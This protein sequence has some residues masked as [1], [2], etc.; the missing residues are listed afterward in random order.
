MSE[1]TEFRS[2]KGIVSCNAK[3]VYLFVTNIE[4]FRQFIP[5]DTVSEWISDDDSCRFQVNGI[6]TVNIMLSEKVPYSKVVYKGEALQKNNFS[7]HLDISGKDEESSVAG[8]V[9]K[10]EMDP[11]MKMI[12]TK[13]A[14]RFLE[15]LVSEME[16]FRNW[17]QTNEKA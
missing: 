8:L 7:I 16:K 1:I 2:R 11:F 9:L 5:S 12:I 6:G 10:A 17:G 3:D 13:P 4:N 14:E 15:L